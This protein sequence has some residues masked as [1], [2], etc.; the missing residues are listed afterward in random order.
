MSA[1]DPAPAR[2]L[3]S[4]GVH[5][6]VEQPLA[7]VF[8]CV[9]FG[10][11]LI[12]P[13][14]QPQQ[15]DLVESF[16]RAQSLGQQRLVVSNVAQRLRVDERLITR[17]ILRRMSATRTQVYLTAEQRRQVDE[18]AAA[19]GVTMA[20]VIRRALDSYLEG[21]RIDPVASLAGTFGVLPEMTAPSRDEWD[22]G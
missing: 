2:L 8:L 19:E 4:V 7:D 22:R 14:E 3:S 16:R 11:R 21:Q 18:I 6:L 12:Q 20:N 10:Q 17:C 15:P 13:A 5:A 9:P 1:A